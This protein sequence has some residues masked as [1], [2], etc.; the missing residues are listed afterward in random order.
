MEVSWIRGIPKSSILMGFSLLKPSILGYPHLWK[1]PHGMGGYCIK[2]WG[3]LEW[4]LKNQEQKIGI[5]GISCN[6]HRDIVRKRIAM[7]FGCVGTWGSMPHV[8]YLYIYIFMAVSRG[9]M[10]PCSHGFKGIPGFRTCPQDLSFRA[11]ALHVLQQFR[12]NLLIRSS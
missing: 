10:M 8:W 11:F 4:Q 9:K 1:P 6:D 2:S 3:G 7:I 5:T 12:A